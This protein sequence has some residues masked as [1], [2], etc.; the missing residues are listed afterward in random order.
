[1]PSRILPLEDKPA[2][3]F[4]HSRADVIAR[5]PKP[6]GRVLDVG[7]GAGA[8]GASLRDAG[9]AHLVGIEM[10]R[11]AAS[12]ARDIFDVVYEGDAESVLRDLVAGTPFDVVCCYDILEHL[13]DPETVL[14]RLH[15]V[16]A[17]NGI[18]HISIPN[19]RHLSL[20]RDLLLRGT[21]GY[22]VFG[23]RD[24]TH[25]RWFT[26]SDIVMFLQECGWTVTEVTTH[27][28]RPLRALLARLSGGYAEE[29]F[30]VQW[31]IQCR[32]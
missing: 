13:Y 24:A 29:F 30:A 32:A 15:H 21:F 23:H 6:L 7:C 3:Y 19:A 5:L 17:P 27:R 12:R 25:L 18:L 28:L 31:W 22:E 1:M 2:D 11:E 26:K 4:E 16:T 10:N 9:A 20:V 14:R 8:V